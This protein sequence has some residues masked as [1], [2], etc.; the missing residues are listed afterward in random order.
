[1]T[2]HSKVGN[3]VE[4]VTYEKTEF[5]VFDNSELKVD[6]KPLYH[7]IHIYTALDS[8]DELRKSYQADR[9][10][11][12]DLILPTPIPLN[13]LT[14]LIQEVAG[15]FIVETHVLKT[16]GNFRSEQELEELWDSLLGR[17]CL[18]LDNAL[19][20]ETDP[21]GYVRV[22]EALIGFIMTMETYEYPTTG[23]HSFILILFEKYSNLLERQFGKRFK[24]I[25]ER[26]DS[27]PM[28]AENEQERNGIMNGV[29]LVRAEREKL[30]RR[31]FPLVFPWSQCFYLCCD[32]IRNFVK[33]FYHF[34]EGVA[35]H[36]R[37]IDELLSKSLDTLLSTHISEN[38]AQRVTSV[39]NLSEIA[40]IAENIE[41]FEACCAELERSLTNIRAVQRG[42]VVRIRNATGSFSKTLG[43]T[44]DRI[45]KVIS[46]KVDDLLSEYEW[47]PQEPEGVPTPYLSTLFQWLNTVIDS[48]ALDAKYK[49]RAYEGAT[50]YIN[51]FYMDVLTSRANPQLVNQN[52]LENVLVDIQFLKDQFSVVGLDN[53]SGIFDE[54][55][56]TANI[57]VNDQVAHYQE[58]RLARFALVKPRRLQVL[59]EKL[60]RY[61][62][63]RSDRGSRE[64]A[65]KRR[66]EAEI[67][68]RIYP[69]EGR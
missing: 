68:G 6:F 10:A 53:L 58:Q 12:S 61:G 15:F 11:Q 5:D 25:V 32:D 21:E 33:K 54:L 65:E 28:Q 29:W 44:L 46:K 26:D 63:T 47:T 13:G 8:L 23:L 57:P 27:V 30:L 24:D 48:L 22:K 4:L 3:A 14:S 2:K 43:I 34:I 67:I 42:G 39:S 20:T 66:K 17:L 45:P 50:A 56:M 37:N 55:V 64:L 9:R 60:A 18:A 35:Q 41:H 59:L 31:P 7:C 1:M 62:T 51:D 52:A 19:G 49:V 16:T 69:G 36:H 40:Q 38:I